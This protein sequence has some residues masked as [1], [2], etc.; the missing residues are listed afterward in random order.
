MAQARSLVQ[1]MQEFGILEYSQVLEDAEWEDLA[2]SSRAR[3]IPVSDHYR[4]LAASIRLP[5]SYLP[6]V[7]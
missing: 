3:R 2:P 4:P 1:V 7:V 5:E 6:P